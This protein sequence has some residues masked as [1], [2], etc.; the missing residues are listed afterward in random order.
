M[1]TSDEAPPLLTCKE[2]SLGMMRLMR[3]PAYWPRLQWI[4]TT[5][6]FSASLGTT[7]RKPEHLVS[8]NRDLVSRVDIGQVKKEEKSRTEGRREDCTQTG[9]RIGSRQTRY[10]LGRYFRR[11]LGWLRIIRL[12]QRFDKSFGGRQDGYF[13]QGRLGKIR[14][15]NAI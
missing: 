2:S 5:K 10:W 14:P 3:G 11:L 1:T 12:Q 7:R 6:S 8:K 9:A 15:G 13:F 4:N